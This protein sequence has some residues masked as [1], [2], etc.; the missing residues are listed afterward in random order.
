MQEVQIYHRKLRQKCSGAYIAV[1]VPNVEYSIFSIFFNWRGL[2][3]GGGERHL[4]HAI[5]LLWNAMEEELW[6]L[7]CTKRDRNKVKNKPERFHYLAE[8]VPELL[9]SKRILVEQELY[10]DKAR[11]FEDNKPREVKYLETSKCIFI[12]FLRGEL[13]FS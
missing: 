11:E 7:F 3:H 12:S 10:D 8:A 2:Q 9:E 6:K 4:R 1:V 13:R 5:T